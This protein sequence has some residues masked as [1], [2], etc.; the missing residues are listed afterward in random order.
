MQ[1]KLILY[2]C[3]TVIVFLSLKLYFSFLGPHVIL[4]ILEKSKTGTQTLLYII[5]FVLGGAF[6]VGGMVI[7][8]KNHPLQ[9][10]WTFKTVIVLTSGGFLSAIGGVL[11]SAALIYLFFDIL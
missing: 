1:R 2:T 10:T 9:L 7:F 8:K 3:M 5:L 6:V 4:P 11:C